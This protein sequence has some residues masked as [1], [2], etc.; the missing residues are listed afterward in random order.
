MLHPLLGGRDV[1]SPVQLC[2]FLEDDVW[3]ASTMPHLE[4]KVTMPLILWILLAS[5]I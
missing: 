3:N 5:V 1:S 4:Y 2:C